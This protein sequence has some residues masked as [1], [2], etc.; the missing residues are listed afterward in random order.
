MSKTIEWE[1]PGLQNAIVLFYEDETF[2]NYVAELIDRGFQVWCSERDYSSD[3]LSCWKGIMEK[4]ESFDIFNLH[5]RNA[6][7]VILC[8]VEYFDTGLGII[9]RSGFVWSLN[10]SRQGSIPIERNEKKETF[11]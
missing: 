2:R 10:F 11:F 5:V 3:W 4:A 6:D 1:G 8:D 7:G 9:G